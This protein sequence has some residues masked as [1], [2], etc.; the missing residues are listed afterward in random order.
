RLVL[1]LLVWQRPNLLLLDEPTNHLDLEM[2]H[3]VV[4]ALQG[5]QGATVTVSHDRHLLSSTVDEYFLVA[6]GRVRR[7]DGDLEDYR[8]WLN[9][10]RRRRQTDAIGGGAKKANSA[11]VRK[12]ERRREAQ[13]RTALKP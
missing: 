7:F 9:E 4:V 11:A 1:A 5:F 13:Q 3:A 6:D 12:A 8:Q 2:R 10:R